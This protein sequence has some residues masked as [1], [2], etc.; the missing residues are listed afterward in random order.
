MKKM[1]TAATI[2]IAG[3][4]V[5]AG[6]AS[7]ADGCSFG[8]RGGVYCAPGARPGVPYGYYGY[9]GYPYGRPHAYHRRYDPGAAIALGVIGA[10]AA[11]IAGSRRGH[12]RRYRHR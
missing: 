12:H 4:G 11:A 1:I 10:A 6:T 2:A 7:A 3:F 8:Y 5:S 9:G